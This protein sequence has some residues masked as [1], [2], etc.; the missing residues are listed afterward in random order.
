M[1]REKCYIFAILRLELR[2]FKTTPCINPVCGLAGSCLHM[3][4]ILECFPLKDSLASDKIP[5]LLTRFP[6]FWQD[7]LASVKISLLLTRFSCLCQ[8]SLASDKI[9]LPLTG[10][11]CLWQDSPASV[12]ISLPLSIFPCLCQDSP[13]AVPPPLQSAPRPYLPLPPNGP[14]FGVRHE[15]CGENSD[16]R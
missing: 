15:P 10:F 12:N 9:P 13:A 3:F 14:N 2:F 1:P 6:C 11:P 16:V 5:L 4:P 8:D 7:S